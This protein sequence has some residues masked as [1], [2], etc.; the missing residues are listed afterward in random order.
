LVE[1]AHPCYLLLGNLETDDFTVVAFPC[2]LLPEDYLSRGLQ[3]IGAA[4]IVEGK[5]ASVFLISL[6][7]KALDNLAAQ[8]LERLDAVVK[9][10]LA[11]PEIAER[12]G[13]A[14]FSAFMQ[15]LI[16]L[17]DLRSQSADE[18]GAER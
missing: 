14:A 10:L 13:T 4:G 18:T 8:V 3:M 6:D 2:G 9:R 11:N 12:A 5:P 16:S 15:H 17:P 1:R 7:P